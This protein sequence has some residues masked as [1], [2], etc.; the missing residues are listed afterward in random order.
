MTMNK[1]KYQNWLALV[2]ISVTLWSCDSLLEVEPRD[3]VSIQQQ[4]SSFRG[5]LQALNG[6]YFRYE[7]QYSGLFFIYSDLQGGNTTFSPLRTGSNQGIISIPGNVE[8]TYNFDEDA[9]NSPFNPFYS[10]SYENLNNLNNILFFLPQIPDATESQKKQVRAEALVMRAFIHYN[11]QLLYSQTLQ[12]SSDGSHP[13]IVYA[14]RRLQGGIDF[15]ARLPAA[16]VF[17]K[18]QEDLDEALTLFQ[19]QSAM[20]GPVHSYWNPLNTLALKAR[21]ALQQRDWT[22]ALLWSQEVITS[23]PAL[24]SKVDYVS[25]WELPNTPVSEVLFEFSPPMSSTGDV[26]SSSVSQFYGIVLGANQSVVDYGRYVSSLDLI[27]MFEED[28]V[29][30]ANFVEVFLPVRTPQGNQNQL[31]YFTKKFQDNA[32]A[33]VLRQSEMYLIAAEAAARLNQPALALNYLNTIRERAGVAPIVQSP[34]LLGLIFDER[35][36]ELCFEGHLFYD[37]GRFGRNVQ[38]QLGCLSLQCNL[39]FPNPRFV[40]PIPLSTIQLNE[41]MVQNEG[42]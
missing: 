39:N 12:F 28:D 22:N 40:L 14:D 16:R 34:D 21:V 32:G 1:R 5:A 42:Y 41:N 2:I 29:R 11:L 18:I 19:T 10:N 31:F 37:I 25:Q 13:G 8:R 17:E 3:Q 27:N 35:R 9:I 7:A 36:R 24:M 26:V 30:R 23:G 15:P 20:P 38:R 33:L 6:V 4:F